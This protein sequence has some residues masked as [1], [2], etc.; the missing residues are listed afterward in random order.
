MWRNEFMSD[1]TKPKGFDMVKPYL[2]F[3]DTNVLF[4]KPV[5]CLCAISSLLIPVYFLIQIFQYEI[6][7]SR[8]P[9]LITASLLLLLVLV[10]AGVFG[11]LIWW[12]RRII[13][14]EGPKA[15]NNFR[16]FVQTLGEWTATVFAIVVFFGVLIVMICAG[17]E[18]YYISGL[19]PLPIPA[20]DVS[21]ALFGLVGGFLI[22]IATK[23]L[24]FLLDP[25]IWLVK[26]IWILFKRIVLYFYRCVIKVHGTIEQNTPVWVGV[27]WLISVLVVVCGLILCFRVFRYSSG[28]F[29]GAVITVALGLAYMGFLVIKRRSHDI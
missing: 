1:E 11:S 12:H 4:K 15:Y 25:V 22:I 13:R 3:I 6:F 8:S 28:I 7:E 16:R 24:L 29:I 14:D 19:I 23:I 27:T 18:Y 9:G 2:G 26:Q 21:I 10:F 5:S 20:I 17:N